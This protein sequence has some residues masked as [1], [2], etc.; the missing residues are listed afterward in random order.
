MAYENLGGKIK[1][2]KEKIRTMRKDL[3]KIHSG[4]VSPV[5]KTE[6]PLIPS[7]EIEKKIAEVKGSERKGEK[8]KRG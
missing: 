8:R 3:E 5:Q 1:I 2:P 4:G 6:K 7:Q